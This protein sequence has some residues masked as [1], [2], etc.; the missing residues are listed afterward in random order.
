[1]EPQAILPFAVEQKKGSGLFRSWINGLW[2]AP[3]DLKR[4][5][6]QNEA[7]T[8][9]YIP[10][11]T[12]NSDT[13][14]KFNGVDDDKASDATDYYNTHENGKYVTRTRS[15]VD[16]STTHKGQIEK[17]FENVA[18][19]ASKSLPKKHV[20]ELEPWEL[21]NLVPFNEK[22]LSGFKTESYQIDLKEGFDDA[23]K[24]M[25]I[26]IQNIA[27][28]KIGG[29]HPH[30]YSLRTVYD[31]IKFKHVLLPIWISAY[32]YNGKVYRF[33]ING[34]TGE[35]QGERPWSWIKI[36]FAVLLFVGSIVALY[37]TPKSPIKFYVFAG[38]IGAFVIYSIIQGFSN[39]AKKE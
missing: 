19:V 11:W 27:R 36:T 1:M 15:N 6:Q 33:V 38:A 4:H 18:V 14:T 22:Y 10:F 35:V 31:S 7:I 23:M 2:F 28:K 34:R 9:L 39:S 25:T 29:Q 24:K 17:F 20:D 12:Y 21:E 26:E 32:N 37:A 8:G 30:I 3:N 13:S 5:L 16:D